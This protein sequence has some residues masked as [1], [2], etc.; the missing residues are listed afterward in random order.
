MS[1]K[2]L[3]APLALCL[4]YIA[5]VLVRVPAVGEK[6][7]TEK[8]VAY[9]RAQQITV[10]DVL[11]NHLPSPPNQT[12]DDTTILGVDSNG[13]GVRDDVELSI[14]ASTSLPGIRASELQYAHTLQLYLT[15]VFDK[16]TWRAVS[17]QEDRAFQ[18]LGQ[19]LRRAGVKDDELVSATLG[20]A[21]DIKSLVFNTQARKDAHEKAMNFITSFG[22]ESQTVCDI[23]PSTL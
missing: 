3:W 18:C 11:G 1:Q 7:K 17:V 14:F 10:R 16:E 20:R 19:A 12:Q 4:L 8:T 13:N 15:D 22:L 2:I 6:E 9:I 5:L 23:D 21:A